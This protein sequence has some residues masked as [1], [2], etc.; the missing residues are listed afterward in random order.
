SSGNFIADLTIGDFDNDTLPDIMTANDGFGSSVDSLMNDS[1]TTVDAVFNVTID[2]PSDSIIT[3]DYAVV[4]GTATLAGPDYVANSGTLTFDPG[5]TSLQITVTVLPDLLQEDNEAFT[6]ELMNATQAVIVD[7]VGDGVI[8]NDDGPGRPF[9]TVDDVTIVAEGN[10]GSQVATFTV[11][12][13]NPPFTFATSV[14]FTTVSGSAVA[15]EDFVATSGTLVFPFGVT[16]QTVSVVVTG[17]TT[18]EATEVARLRL[19]NATAGVQIADSDGVLTIVD[20]DGPALAGLIGDTLNGGIGNDTLTGS[21]LS[22]V[23][24]GMAGNDSLDGGEGNDTLLGGSGI[25]TLNGGG[26]NDSLLGQG[27]AD[28]LE[29]GLEDD[30]IVWRGEQ[31]ADDTFTLEEGFDTIQINGNSSDNSFS[32]G[33]SGSTLIIS[34]GNGSLSISGDALGFV[35]GSEVIEINGGRGNDTITINDINNVGFF[36][37]RVNGD[38]GTDTITGSGALVGNVPI[39]ID[40]GLGD[41]TLNGTT[42]GDL[43]FGRAGLDT[44]DAQGGADTLNGGDGDDI[45]DGGD[46]NDIVRGEA[47]NDSVTGGLGDDL[48]EGGFGNDTLFGSDGND[49]AMG[50]FG[51]DILNGMAGDDSL[52]GMLGRDSILGGNGNDTLDGGRD[53]DLMTGQGGNDVLRGDHGEDTLRG[54]G[55]DDTIDAGDGADLVNAGNGKDAIFGGDGNDTINGESGADTIDGHDGDDFVNAG[56]GDDIIVGGDG[57]DTINGNSGTDTAGGNLGDDLIGSSEVIDDM[58]ILSDADRAKLNAQI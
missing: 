34:E 10:T 1:Q 7:G 55:G 5:V 20:D 44:I 33:Q 49:T 2:E 18:P 41:D 9:L 17:D 13:Q 12:L 37:L 40:G 16:T 54:G 28:V 32:I 25:D 26:G 15:A 43:I 27:G 57:D 36:V 11:T 53:D 46:G 50:S 48:L 39:I 6:V 47:G 29:G 42:G 14:D 31:D 21:R 8:V 38:A 24:N 22:D 3:I 56:G 19:S 52:M 51:D 30:I 23:L 58:L 4:D 35:A 45:I